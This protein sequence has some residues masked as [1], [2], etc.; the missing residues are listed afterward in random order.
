MSHY[1]NLGNFYLK[2]NHIYDELR[3]SKMEVLKMCRYGDIYIANKNVTGNLHHEKQ[4]V[5][6]VSANNSN[7]SSSV[8]TIVPIIDAAE[9]DK[10]M[11]YVY[12]GDY[13]MCEKNI[14]VIEQ[15]TTLDQPQL[16]VK[17]GSIR[18]T[19]YGKQIKQEIKSYLGL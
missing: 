11:S 2:K 9:Q 6:V 1:R 15:I 12:I 19:A 14:A 7:K 10:L 4:T 3:I 16:L 17:I 18:G 5:L 13:G 8:V